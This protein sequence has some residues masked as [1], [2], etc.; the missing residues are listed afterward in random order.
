MGYEAMHRLNRSAP[1]SRTCTQISD[2]LEARFFEEWVEQKERG[3][4][5]I[6]TPAYRELERRGL[7]GVFAK[8]DQLGIVT[9]RH[10]TDPS[11]AVNQGSDL[12][13]VRRS[14]AA[15]VIV[16]IVE[17]LAALRTK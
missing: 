5:R 3:C 4:E 13:D 12:R 8:L 15:S 14:H 6:F 16:H 10:Q 9:P 2:Y 17:K 11:E 1:L 7:K